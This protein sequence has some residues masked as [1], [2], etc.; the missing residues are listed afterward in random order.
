M[1]LLDPLTRAVL[2]LWYRVSPHHRR[3]AAKRRLA[4]LLIEQGLAGKRQADRIASM[5]YPKR[6]TL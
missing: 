1:P 6:W 4:N 5:A 3:I 2:A